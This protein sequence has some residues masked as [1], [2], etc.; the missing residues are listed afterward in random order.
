MCVAPHMPCHLA[1]TFYRIADQQ[2][3]KMVC[4][5]DCKWLLFSSKTVGKNAKQVSLRASLW[6]WRAREKLRYPEP[7]VTVSDARASGG[8]RSRHHCSY[9]INIITT[10]TRPADVPT[11][12]VFFASEISTRLK[13]LSV[14]FS[15]LLLNI[16]HLEKSFSRQL[17]HGSFLIG[18]KN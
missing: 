13:L 4:S 3:F 8:S 6:K 10:P 11:N 9:I 5:I 18:P 17:R 12:N 7:V 14:P 2:S 16:G 1:W 15:S